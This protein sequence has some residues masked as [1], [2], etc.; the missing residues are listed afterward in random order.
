MPILG[1]VWRKLD[2]TIHIIG[3]STLIISNLIFAI[4]ESIGRLSA[5]SRPEVV[6]PA[7]R[8]VQ[9]KSHSSSNRRDLVV[10]ALDMFR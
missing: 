1:T 9:I 3:I 8:T 7:I 5:I 4:G 6:H 2:T 10:L